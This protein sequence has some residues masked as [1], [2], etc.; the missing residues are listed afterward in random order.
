MQVAGGVGGLVMVLDK[1]A[2]ATNLTSGNNF[3]PLADR[4][5]C[6]FNF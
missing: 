4:M 6:P 2:S 1:N 3:F 5:S